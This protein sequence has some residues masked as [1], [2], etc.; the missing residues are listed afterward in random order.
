ME[1]NNFLDQAKISDK[2]LSRAKFDE[3]GVLYTYD[4]KVLIKCP[5]KLEHINIHPKTTTIA[6]YAFVGCRIKE[7]ILPKALKIIGHH[8]FHGSSIESLDIPDNVLYI[9]HN[10]F[11]WCNKLTEISLP[12]ELPE[13]QESTFQKCKCLETIDIPQ[14]ITTI[15]GGCFSGCFKIDINIKGKDF[16]VFKGC[17]YQISRKSLI[18]CWSLERNI[19]L[20]NGLQRIENNAFAACKHFDSIKI[21]NTVIYIGNNLFGDYGVSDIYIPKSVEII[22]PFAFDHNVKNIFVQ[23]GKTDKVKAMLPS[24]YHKCIQERSKFLFV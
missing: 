15:G 19:Q 14:S 12:A 3:Q 13:L 20:A 10:A 16:K 9:G 5:D 22:E 7:I 18:A 21:P 2:E 23:K 24:T 17:L 11:R 4:N 8:A 6:N 1:T